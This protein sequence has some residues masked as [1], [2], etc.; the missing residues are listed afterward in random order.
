MS[1]FD[2]NITSAIENIYHNDKYQISV[3]IK[4]EDQIH[5]YVSGNK[6]RKLKYNLLE[7]IEQK[8]DTILTYGG[9][10]SNHIVATAVASKMNNLKSIGIIRGDEIEEKFNQNPE[11]N[12][13]LALAHAQGMTLYFVSRKQYRL[14]NELMEINHLKQKFG[15][16]YRIPEGGT[17]ALAVKGCMEIL[18][19]A[20]NKYDLICC[21]VGTGGTLA[22]I[23]SAS[24]PHQSVLGF[25]ALK[26]HNHDN[27][28][29]YVNQQNFE[30]IQDHEF[31]G[32]AKTDGR[33]IAFMNS[34]YRCTGIKTDPIYTG[35]MLYKL[36]KMI[37]NNQIPNQTKIL[38]IHSGGI[39]GIKAFNNFQKSKNRGHLIFQ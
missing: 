18:N 8:H 30:I 2:Q 23:V 12:P 17:N 26:G 11:H 24:K 6:F 25:S 37:E 20:D 36:F 13:T 4:R 39:Q 5:P 3:D 14:K 22:G 10:Y 31:G 21:C 34:F 1:F 9:A 16:F 33:L 7:A 27:I 35:K 38:V 19:S 28:L 15:K 32:Y 29:G